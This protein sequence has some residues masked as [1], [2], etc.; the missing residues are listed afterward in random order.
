MRRSPEAPVCIQ[1]CLLFRYRARF[2]YGVWLA[3][4]TNASRFQTI[5]WAT[6][7]LARSLNS[8]GTV[9]LFG[10]PWSRLSVPPLISSLIVS[11]FGQGLRLKFS[12][13]GMAKSVVGNRRRNRARGGTRDSGPA[14]HHVSGLP[15]T[16][17]LR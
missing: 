10:G 4:T 5:Y 11:I 1:P 2:L 17:R 13:L 15:Q 16:H 9:A 7:V 12:L 8:G 3:R 14:S 6:I